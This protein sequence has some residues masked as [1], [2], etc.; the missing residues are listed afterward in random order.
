MSNTPGKILRNEWQAL[1][2]EIARD[3]LP[4]RRLQIVLGTVLYD[5]EDIGR[6][7]LVASKRHSARSPILTPLERLL[8]FVATAFRNSYPSLKE[9]RS[10]QTWDPKYAGCFHAVSNLRR[11]VYIAYNSVSVRPFSAIERLRLYAAWS[12]LTYWCTQV[13][14]ILALRPRGREISASQLLTLEKRL[15]EVPATDQEIEALRAY[16]LYRR[17]VGAA[18]AQPREPAIAAAYFT[19]VLSVPSTV[20]QPGLY[21]HAAKHL[22]RLPREFQRQVLREC[23]MALATAFAMMREK[24]T[25]DRIGIGYMLAQDAS[26]C[27]AAGLASQTIKRTEQLLRSESRLEDDQT[28][29]VD[30]RRIRWCVMRHLQSEDTLRGN[31]RKIERLVSTFGALVESDIHKAAEL[32]RERKPNLTL[33]ARLYREVAQSWI[34]RATSTEQP[35]TSASFPTQLAD[36]LEKRRNNA[37]VLALLR[38]GCVCRL[39]AATAKER[40]DEAFEEYERL[41][42]FTVATGD[43]QSL[44][45]Q[46]RTQGYQRFLQ[47][48]GFDNEAERLDSLGWYFEKVFGL[49]AT[50]GRD[51][52]APIDRLLFGKDVLLVDFRPALDEIEK[53]WRKD[54][55]SERTDGTIEEWLTACATAASQGELTAIYQDPLFRKLSADCDTVLTL[56]ERMEHDEHPLDPVPTWTSV[57][58]SALHFCRILRKLG[59]VVLATGESDRF[60]YRT[61]RERG[62]NWANRAIQLARQTDRPASIYRALDVR[63]RLELENRKK[64]DQRLIRELT[65]EMLD[66]DEARLKTTNHSSRRNRAVVRAERSLCEVMRPLCSRIKKAVAINAD[67]EVQHH[68]ALLQRFKSFNFGQLSNGSSDFDESSPEESVADQVISESPVPDVL[69]RVD[70]SSW[71]EAL[72][73]RHGAEQLYIHLR[74]QKAVIL[75]FVTHPGALSSDWQSAINN[76][77]GTVCFVIKA[78]PSNLLIR[79]IFLELPE[80]L[81]RAVVDGTA[82]SEQDVDQSGL[83]TDLVYWPAT[84]RTDFPDLLK[85]FSDRLFPQS[86][87]QELEGCR[88]VYLCPHR[89][90]F[91]VPLHAFPLRNPLFVN[92]YASYAIKTAHIADMLERP[93]V[94]SKSPHR[95]WMMVDRNALEGEAW[96][97]EP[98][99]KQRNHWRS[100]HVSADQLIQEAANAD[101]AVVCCHGQ[102]DDV[103]PGRTRFRLWGGGRLVADDLHRVAGTGAPMQERSVSFASSDWV[104]AAC[105]AGGARVA[106]RTA[107]GLALSLVTSGAAR[108]TSCIFRVQ[109]KLAGRFL[110]SFLSECDAGHRAPFTAAVRRLYN[111]DRKV[112]SIGVGWA[113]AA[114]FTSYGLLADSNS[115]GGSSVIKKSRSVVDR[116]ARS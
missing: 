51:S 52:A 78:G 91:Q 71:A 59:S 70:V 73:S 89:H 99:L 63:K 29:R 21:F 75:D 86:L 114:S 9:A 4:R 11:M 13:H 27:G 98:W 101:Q 37:D 100:P 32:L 26:L 110:N 50:E 82:G 16:C 45:D 90:L 107:P 74:Q 7:Y 5:G 105:N 2:G 17:A 25:L 80:A 88:S 10:H 47:K 31:H 68:F 67:I 34:E 92:F 22:L 24:R 46:L 20:L 83:S 64:P 76:R 33:L 42:A 30:S 85:D 41:L 14:P 6:S 48:L 104:I 66:I 28:I 54:H 49:Q 44:I 106:M 116:L 95:R 72:G 69:E 60:S 81:I 58:W 113:E 112:G 97:I 23:R 53:S 35:V 1:L 61:W 65:N 57:A 94:C 15:A 93:H 39:L 36:A 18:T 40:I 96:Q 56:V 38:A 79:P 3:R 103:R 12:N 111:Q 19:R 62:V 43:W 84:P 87:L 115:V 109:P 8:L 55:K 77:W 108:V 102:L